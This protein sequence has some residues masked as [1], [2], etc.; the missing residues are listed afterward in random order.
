MG[1]V[2]SAVTPA[3]VAR[4]ARAMTVK[5]AVTGIPHGGGK[6]GIRVAQPLAWSD[7][8][9]V[10]RAFAEA[11]RPLVDYIPGP[12]MGTDETAMAWIRDEI[13]ATGYGL[14]VCAEALAAAGRLQLSGVRVQGANLPVTAGAEAVLAQR[15]ILSV[16]EEVLSSRAR[17]AGAADGVAR[18][19]TAA[20]TVI[21][22]S[23]PQPIEH[24]AARHGGRRRMRPE[25]SCSYED[26][27]IVKKVG[28]QL[29]G[30]PQSAW[31]FEQVGGTR[32]DGQPARSRQLG[33]GGPIEAEDGVVEAADDEQGRRMDA[34]QSR[35]GQVGSAAAGDDRGDVG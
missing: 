20:T 35:A 28:G 15:G 31:F 22:G 5:N 27:V 10:V 1:Y 25:R 30:G 34:V 18:S 7:R 19:G 8:E 13:G 9:P 33:L 4:L 6:A 17:L 12:D 2:S 11:I 26:Q 16:P 24:P 32:H 23:S 14:A 21:T 3:E 29:G